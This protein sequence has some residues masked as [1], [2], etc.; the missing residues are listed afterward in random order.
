[1]AVP[2]RIGH[3]H[4][5]SGYGTPLLPVIVLPVGL[6]VLAAHNAYSPVQVVMPSVDG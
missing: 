1:M 5:T 6:Q 2:L 4:S 3:L